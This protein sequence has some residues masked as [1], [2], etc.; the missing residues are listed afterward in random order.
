MSLPDGER[1][2]EEGVMVR[3]SGE[4]KGQWRKS[5]YLAY[6]EV[7]WSLKKRLGKHCEKVEDWAYCRVKG[8]MEKG[9]KFGW[10][11]GDESTEEGVEDWAYWRV[12]GAREKGWK[13][14]WLRGDGNTEEG[15]KI[16]HLIEWEFGWQ[17][18]ERSTEERVKIGF[19]RG[20]KGQWRKGWYTAQ[21]FTVQWIKGKYLAYLK[22]RGSLKKSWEQH[23][24]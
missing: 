17:K 8:A 10:L 18:G 23:C 21:S 2:S 11:K 16:G 9:W 24:R 1:G 5:K 3:F 12:K 13:I 22:V 14:G 6:W 15:L 4:W 20:W 7:S 19:T